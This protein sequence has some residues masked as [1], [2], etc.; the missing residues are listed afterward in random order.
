MAYKGMRPGFAEE[1]IDVAW[2]TWQGHQAQ[3]RRTRLK[4]LGYGTAVSALVLLLTLLPVT[5]KNEVATMNPSVTALPRATSMKNVNLL[6]TSQV[7]LPNATITLLLDKNV[8]LVGYPNDN[9]ISWRAPIVAGDN[10][11]VLPVML[12]GKEQGVISISVDADTWHKRMTLAV[13]HQGP[14]AI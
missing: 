5:S 14:R 8:R 1:A 4:V 7:P 3:R 2:A 11:L 9:H 13:S 10:K 12:H 6:V